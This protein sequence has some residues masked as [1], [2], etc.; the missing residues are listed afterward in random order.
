MAASNSINHTDNPLNFLALLTFVVGLTACTSA[1]LSPSP[2]TSACQTCASAT[3]PRSNPGATPDGSTTLARSA[4]YQR[5][6]WSALPGWQRDPVAQ[7]WGAWLRS[8]D[9]LSRKSP[10]LWRSPCEAAQQ[11]KQPMTD[12][13]A[14]SFF[15]Q[16]F[17]PYRIENADGSSSPGL[18]TGYYEPLLRG[19]RQQSAR[20]KVPL[21]GLPSDLLQIDLSSEYPELQ[22][23]RVRGKLM[24]RRIVPYDKRAE[25]DRTRRLYPQAV[26]WVDDVLDAFFLEVQGSGRVSLEN[27]AGQPELVRVSY[28]DQNGHPYRSIGRW[29]ADQG[30]LPLEQVSLP[31]IRQWANAHPDRVDQLLQQNPS[32][33]FFKT[34]SLSHAAEAV[35]PSGALG[36]PLTPRRS[37]AVDPLAVPLG[38]PVYLAT[39]YP[40]SDRPLQSLTLA[41]DTGGAIRGAVRADF[42]WGFGESAET[43]AGRMRQTGRLWLLWP[44]AGNLP[45]ASSAG[46]VP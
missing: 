22:G 23:K 36:V 45:M 9:T 8:C 16:Y 25:L 10:T 13:Q 35:G 5:V 12:A 30:E 7:A 27:T 24:G 19:S 37:I 1:P 33:V 31:S 32:V 2:A 14:R 29:L 26:L 38:A 39:T 34:Q 42:F 21:Y 41:Q 46:V 6:E 20:F 28:A 43:Q 40:A 44:K 4:R 17:A 11:L 3:A 18:V 15:E